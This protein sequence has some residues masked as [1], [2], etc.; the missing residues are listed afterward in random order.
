M[1]Y[2][3]LLE[4]LEQYLLPVWMLLG[5]PWFL[6]LFLSIVAYMQKPAIPMNNIDH[7]TRRNINHPMSLFVADETY[8]LNVGE[9]IPTK[10]FIADAV[11][12]I[13]HAPIKRLI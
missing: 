9:T 13:L 8:L 6:V 5:I 1:I 11:L 7:T 4:V 10:S 3:C 2:Q 12:D